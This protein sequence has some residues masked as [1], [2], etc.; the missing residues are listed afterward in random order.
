MDSTLANLGA[1]Y[2]LFSPLATVALFIILATQFKH[3][4]AKAFCWFA[5]AV[6]GIGWVVNLVLNPP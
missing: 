3:P 4:L 2:R 1:I 5:A 6:L